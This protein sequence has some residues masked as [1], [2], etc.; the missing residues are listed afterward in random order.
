MRPSVLAALLAQAYHAGM[1]NSAPTGAVLITGTA[2][3]GEMLTAD[4]TSVADADGLGTFSYQWL[5]GGV[6]ISGATASM[7]VVTVADVGFTLQARVSFIDGAGK[8]ESVTSSATAVVAGGADGVYETGIYEV[9][10]Y[11]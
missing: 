4:A 11:E 10:V 1:G 7:Y 2:A 3:V 5:R 8:P 9:G 6:P